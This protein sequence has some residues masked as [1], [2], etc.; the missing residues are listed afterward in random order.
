MGI[1]LNKTLERLLQCKTPSE[2]EVEL[3]CEKAKEIFMKEEN[4]ISVPSPVT[5]CGDTH[6]Q[7]YDLI[8]LF[9]IAG[10]PPHI[11]YLFMGD[12]VD[13]G[14]HSVE[15]LSLLLCLKVLYPDRMWLLRGNH[16]SRQITQVYGFYDECMRKFATG[17]VW[18]LFT[19]LF[20]YLPLSAVVNNDIFCCHGGLSP[21]FETLDDLREIN[22]NVE[23]PHTG[24]MCDLLWSDP[25]E[26][27]GWSMSP[28]GAGYVFGKTVTDKFNE[29]NKIKMICRGH[30]LVNDGFSWNH[31]E[32]CVTIFTAPNYCYRCGNTAA[33]M[34]LNETGTY[35]FTQFDPS[36]KKV[37]DFVSSKIPDYF[38]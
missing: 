30:Q 19:D 32:T 13:R 21:N 38:I 8:E 34:E 31:E 6:G 36:P 17:G 7:F 15:T 24:V 10:M 11:N 37:E 1:D 16:E 9:K 20:D 2:E 18:K 14:Y 22:R 23:V 35:D 3:L 26:E 12:Y 33:L 29:R 27:E 5:I 25:V 28:R 4:V